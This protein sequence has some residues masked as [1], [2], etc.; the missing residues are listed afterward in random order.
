V[1]H[2]GPAGDA[3][4]GGTGGVRALSRLYSAGAIWTNEPW[5]MPEGKAMELCI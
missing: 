1:N 2:C 4:D 5:R 3:V